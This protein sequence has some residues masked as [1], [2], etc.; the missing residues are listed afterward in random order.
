MREHLQ[1]SCWVENIMEQVPN[2]SI[3]DIWSEIKGQLH[4]LR[5]QFI[6][7]KETSGRPSW[8]EKGSV[9]VDEEVRNK[10]LQEKNK[11]HRQWMSH[12]DR[13]DVE[14]F[15]LKYKRTRNKAKY[16][17]R[18]AKRLY[19][20]KIAAEAKLNPKMFWSFTHGKLKTKSGVSPLL[21]NGEDPSSTKFDD[22]EKADIL[23][24]QFCG[25][26]TREPEGEIPTLPRRTE[27]SINIVNI[28]E[29]AVL[30]KLSNLH[31]GKSQGP[32]QLH[33]R[34]LKELA[35]LLVKPITALFQASLNSGIVPDDWKKAY[36]SPIYKKGSKCLAVNYRPVSL[37]SIL[38]KVMESMVR[39]AVLDHLLLDNLLTQKQYGFLS[40][41]STALQL[42]HYLD[43]CAD[44]VARGGTV[45][46]IYLD[47][48]KAFDTVPHRRLIG[49]LEAYGIEG[50][51]L[52]WVH[53][54]LSD[55]VQEVCVNGTRS[56][57]GQVLS[58]IPQGSV[59]GPILFVIYINDLPDNLQTDAY[60]L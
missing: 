12:K 18:R 33:P 21:E 47:F 15:H 39:E 48:S 5:D 44:T 9:P 60:L 43:R 16:A 46:A 54:F 41:R 59:L 38:C 22:K 56:F 14:E 34:L 23:Q 28:I 4:K 1:S 58:G 57:I 36:V 37:T 27:S 31:V 11:S 25:V 13:S 40:G 45:D 42:L 29:E 32:D 8:S 2:M 52:Q 20:K 49:K 50:Q 51:L 19:E 26:F 7:K 17:M 30:K 3:N 10:L 24:K 55:R 53:A 6:P 35:S